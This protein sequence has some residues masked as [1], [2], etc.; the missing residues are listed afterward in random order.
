MSKTGGSQKGTIRFQEEL[1]HG[2]NAGLASTAVKWLEP[3][4]AKYGDGISYAD[5]YTL[6]GVAAIKTMDGPTIPWSSGR[7][8]WAVGPAVCVLYV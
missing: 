5:L 1:A 6:A 4:K 3:I 7:V 8:S 2:G